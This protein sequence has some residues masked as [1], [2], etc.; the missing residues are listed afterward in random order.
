MYL[1]CVL[2]EKVEHCLVVV[3]FLT[4]E[5]RHWCEAPIQK[6]FELATVQCNQVGQLLHVAATKLL[7][8]VLP[9]LNLTFPWSSKRPAC[10]E[11]S[12][13]TSLRLVAGCHT[14]STCGCSHLWQNVRI[15]LP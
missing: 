6:A 11:S 9:M 7:M 5:L 10:T 4:L 15:H 2:T 8:A 12:A 13:T 14:E 3:L 1:I